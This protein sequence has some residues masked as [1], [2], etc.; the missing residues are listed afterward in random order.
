MKVILISGKAQSGKDTFARLFKEHVEPYEELENKRVLILKYG[1][2]LKFVCKKCFGWNGEKDE[3]GRTLLQYVGTDLIRENNPDTFVNCLIE[4]AKGLENKYDYLL[5]P[6]VRF[7]NEIEQWMG[8]GLD[9]VTVRINRLNEDNTPYE[10]N[11]TQ[12]QKRHISETELDN[13]IFDYV[14][15]NRKLLDLSK[16]AVILYNEVESM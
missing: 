6:D 9:Y 2:I 12:E 13:Y 16:D 4:I 7:R 8:S 1:D 10:N 5:V 3:S 15:Y 11:L 14:I